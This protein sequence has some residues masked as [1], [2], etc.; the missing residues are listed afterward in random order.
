MSDSSSSVSNDNCSNDGCS[1]QAKRT[2]I[3]RQSN[4]ENTKDDQ[5]LSAQNLFNEI[6]RAIAAA[7]KHQVL[8]Y[9]GV[10]PKSGFLVTSSLDEDGRVE[11]VGHR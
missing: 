11:A 6:S 8:T 1:D 10:D 9:E 7:T 2:P 5:K 4:R 3:T